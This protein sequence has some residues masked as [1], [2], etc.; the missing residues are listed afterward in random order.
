M[1]LVVHFIIRHKPN[2]TIV[3]MFF[4]I[5]SRK[6]NHFVTEQSLL[7]FTAHDKIT[8]SLLIGKT[9]CV[10]VCVCVCDTRRLI[11]TLFLEVLY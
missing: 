6:K 10:C 9:P 3:V 8:G 1:T 11:R 2:F 7:F 5:H 4:V